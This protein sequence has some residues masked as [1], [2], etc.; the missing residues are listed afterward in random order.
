MNNTFQEVFRFSCV[1]LGQNMRFSRQVLFFS[2]SMGPFNQTLK[3][4]EQKNVIILWS[5]IMGK[6]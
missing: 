4:Y 1:I 5:P 3:H 2:I 6:T